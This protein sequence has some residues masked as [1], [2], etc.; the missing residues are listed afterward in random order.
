MTD[1][2][3]RHISKTVL[4]HTRVLTREASFWED[5]RKSQGKR[6]AKCRVRPLP[7]PGEVDGA[8]LPAST[9]LRRTGHEMDET[10][11]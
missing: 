8:S 7:L 9:K 5:T 11:N 4:L 6:R 3:Q 1:I 10:T 2:L